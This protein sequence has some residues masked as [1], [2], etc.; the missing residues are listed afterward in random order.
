MKPKMS[1]GALLSALV[2]SFPAWSAPV[3]DNSTTDTLNTYFYSVG[4]YTEIGD[5]VTLGGTDRTLTD[6]AVQFYNNGSSTG[7]FDA[8]LRFYS[9]A[10]NPL[11]SFQNVGLTIGGL[12]ILTVT[13]PSL[14]LTVPE[15][16]IFTVAVSNVA[17]GLDLGLNAFEPPSVGQSDSQSIMVDDGTG[18]APG[19]TASG[20]GN[21]YFVANATTPGPNRVLEPSMMGLVAVAFVVGSAVIRR[22]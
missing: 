6:A 16:F 9:L 8:T 7:T 10:Q 3:Y 19:A 2:L 4:A 12:D 15:Q 14:N 21:L 13:F 1:V 20:L 5:A 22:R 11:G 18:L 17:A